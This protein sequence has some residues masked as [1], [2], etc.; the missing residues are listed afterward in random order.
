MAYILFPEQNECASLDDYY[1]ERV[2]L[3]WP[4]GG[5]TVIVATVFRSLAFGDQLWVVDCDIV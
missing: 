2:R 3:I 5:L 1:L 4:L